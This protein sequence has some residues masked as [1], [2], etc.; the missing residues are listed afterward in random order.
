MNDHTIIECSECGH[1]HFDA[2]AADYIECPL[3]SEGCPCPFNPTIEDDEHDADGEEG[4]SFER[5]LWIK[6]GPNPRRSGYVRELPA[7]D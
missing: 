6:A 4:M 5:A 2:T 3:T 7:W 1:L